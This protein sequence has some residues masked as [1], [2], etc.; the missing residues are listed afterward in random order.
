MASQTQTTLPTMLAKQCQTVENP[1]ARGEALITVGQL[2]TAIGEAY[3]RVEFL[4]HAMA[5][6]H[7]TAEQRISVLA[8]NS[9]EVAE[10]VEHTV[11][12]ALQ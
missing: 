9:H 1:V 8:E 2:Q 7:S 5:H 12:V 4:A 3:Q 10:H 6:A 11:D